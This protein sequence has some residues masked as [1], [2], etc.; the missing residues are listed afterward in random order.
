MFKA[1]HYTI[2]KEKNMIFFGHKDEIFIAVCFS[3][4]KLSRRL[5]CFSVD[6]EVN[7]QRKLSNENLQ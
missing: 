4:V 5:T 7:V 3:V 6:T 1:V 2:L